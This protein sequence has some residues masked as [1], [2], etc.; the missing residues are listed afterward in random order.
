VTEFFFSCLRKEGIKKRIY[1]IR[2][3]ARADVFAYIK[4]FHNRPHRQS[5]L[6]TVSPEPFESA[7]K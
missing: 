3:M 4:S 5:H 7:P 6:G 2:D 1:K